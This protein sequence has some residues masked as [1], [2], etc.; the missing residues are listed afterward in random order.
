MRDIDYKELSKEEL[1]ELK[2]CM[3]RNL[4][5]S[6]NEAREIAGLLEDKRYELERLEEI[7]LMIKLCK[8]CIVYLDE[9]IKEK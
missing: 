8:E 2:G 1:M 4:R 6:E 5:S 3:E 9:R 7:E